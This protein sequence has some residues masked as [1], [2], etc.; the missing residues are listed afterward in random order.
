M[1]YEDMSLRSSADI[2]G[3]S[4]D[5]ISDSPWSWPHEGVAPPQD[6]TY[7]QF[8]AEFTASQGE[9][10]SERN[11]RYVLNE[12]VS[13]FDLSLDSPVGDEFELKFTSSLTLFI[14]TVSQTKSKK[15]AQNLGS[16]L[17]VLQ[18]ASEDSK[19]SHG[20][21]RLLKDA[22]Q[23]MLK[24]LNKPVS[25]LG[26]VKSEHR[27]A[28][29]WA[30]GI[31]SPRQTEKNV[32]ALHRLEDLFGLTREALTSRAWPK[33]V[34][35]VA[36]LSDDIPHRRFLE[37]VLTCKYGL[38]L[39]AMPAA[40]KKS[41]E[42][43]TAHRR[44]TEHFLSSG[45][46]VVMDR[47]H[48]WNSSS[49]SKMRISSMERFFGALVLPKS[50][51]VQGD[52]DWAKAITYGLGIPL[53]EIRFTQ[54]VDSKTIFAYMKF[55]EL[56]TF[57]REHFLHYESIVAAKRNGLFPP[58]PTNAP[59]TLP[60]SIETFLALCNSL[61]NKPTSFLRMNPQFGNELSPPIAEDKWEAWCIERNAQIC[62]LIALSKNKI[63]HNKR[64]NKALL[65]P[66]LR[67]ADPRVT[68]MQ[69][70]EAMKQE[71]PADTQP[72]WQARHWRD[73]A[74]IS[75]LNFECLRIKNVALLDIGRHVIERNGRLCLFIP[76]HELK[77]NIWGH[78][79]DIDRE[80]PD[81]VQQTLRTWMTVYRPMF[82][83]HD[84]TNALFV[85][86]ITNPVTKPT[87][88]PHRI[89]SATVTRVMG[90]KSKK[91]LG[92]AIG[93]HAIRNINVTSVV[94]NGGTLSQVKAVLNDSQKTAS[95]AYVD[96]KN[97]DERQ[98]LNDLYNSSRT[99]AGIV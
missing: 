62:K 38:K 50:L 79:E 69:M 80:F 14:N 46:I 85:S 44:Q 2:A 56:R 88:D 15:T 45:E 24:R 27:S 31:S 76:K 98:A 49:T 91:Y 30:K 4:G 17:R 77:N 39:D 40:L 74:M 23:F 83:G 48:V 52:D 55:C 57:D 19:L 53:A 28:L 90:T 5:V 94:R 21:P 51:Q 33:K 68:I 73:I 9:A 86:Y 32:A 47:C 26:S 10:A 18:R 60:A 7:G 93:A 70:V 72:V 96:V 35:Q 58:P 41:I 65:Q 59:K 75:L 78:A 87:D 13:F 89:T 67:L 1:S 8:L 43:L 54:L 25:W 99:K 29:E 82:E 6:L 37:V 16:R 42:E 92:A 95:K 61:V 36:Q 11:D 64:S 20:L 66:I 97:S 34:G 3:S 71:F 12:W 63:E 81:D 84:K 22:I